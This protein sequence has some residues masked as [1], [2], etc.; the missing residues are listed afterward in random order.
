MGG[1]PASNTSMLEGI[2][3]LER[4]MGR[5]MRWTYSDISRAGDHIWYVSDIRRFREHYPEWNLTYALDQVVEEIF[6]EM[7][8]RLSHAGD[9]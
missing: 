1:G 2:A 9:A 5:P 8:D 4:L 3:M 6:L 7:S